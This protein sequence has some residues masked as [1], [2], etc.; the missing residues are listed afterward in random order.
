MDSLF[1]I[2]AGLAEV[3]C[4]VVDPFLW[5]LGKGDGRGND[6]PGA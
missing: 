6:P 3:L 1:E 2:I 4:S 5:F